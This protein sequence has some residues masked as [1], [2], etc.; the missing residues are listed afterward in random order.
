[1]P[2]VRTSPLLLSKANAGKLVTLHRFLEEYRK[3]VQCTIDHA[4][5][6]RLTFGERVLDI[7]NDRL[8]LP[9]F[10]PVACL[11]EMDTPLSGRAIK[12]ATTQAMSMIK[13]ALKRRVKDIAWLSKLDGNPAPRILMQRLNRPLVKPS[14][15]GVSAELNS[16]C[17]KLVW[18]SETSFDGWL[19]LSSLGKPFGR[20]LLPVN[21]HRHL[22]RLAIGTQLASLLI[23]E[24]RA[25]VRFAIEPTTKT[26]SAVRV[27]GADTGL[28]TVL[29]LSDGQTTPE[30][31]CHGHSLQSICHELARKKKGSKAFGRVQD[32]RKNFINWSL[33]QLNLSTLAE[34]HLEKVK[35]IN[36]GRRASRFMQAWTNADIQR[37]VL[38]LA[39][40]QNVS[41]K[42]QSSAYRS[43]RCSC[44][45]MVRKAN[46]KGKVYSCKG[47]GFVCDADLNA[48]RNHEQDLPPIPA[49]FFRTGKNTGEGFYWKSTGCSLPSGVELAVPSSKC[50]A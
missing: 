28:K 49:A 14:A 43:Q 11:P 38:M 25:D 24:T 10:L 19:V 47:C 2:I 34:I 29:S 7:Q 27:V 33:N 44:C 42:L 37:K 50:Q 20:L 4:W 17:A 15:A 1:M 8:E 12:C 23:S 9:S 22:N 3:V 46:R 36:Y 48:A 6:N 32:H 5:N 45:G 21:R 35:H 26:V 30:S 39:E 18:T 16:I 13:A 31:D 41:V 40:E